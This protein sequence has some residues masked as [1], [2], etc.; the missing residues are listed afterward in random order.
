MAVIIFFRQNPNLQT[1]EIAKIL[2][3]TVRRV[4]QVKKE[5]A[6]QISHEG[7]GVVQGMGIVKSPAPS[8]H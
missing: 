6:K 4:Q 1:K 8:H 7:Y 3:V 2:R 5:Y